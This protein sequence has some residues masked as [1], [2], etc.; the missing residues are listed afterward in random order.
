MKKIFISLTFSA[1]IFMLCFTLISFTGSNESG[2]NGCPVTPC[3][4]GYNCCLAYT[5]IVNGGIQT[6]CP[7]TNPTTNSYCCRQKN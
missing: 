1:L 4:S 6:E 7:V 3:P 5:Y 2:S